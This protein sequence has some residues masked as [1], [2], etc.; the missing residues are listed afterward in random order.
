MILNSIVRDHFNAVQRYWIDFLFVMRKMLQLMICSLYSISARFSCSYTNSG[1]LFL[2]LIDPSAYLNYMF[3]HWKSIFVYRNKSMQSRVE[4]N[5]WRK[6]WNKMNLFSLTN[7]YHNT[8]ITQSKQSRWF[9]WSLFCICVF[10]FV[11]FWWTNTHWA[12][13]MKE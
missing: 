5:L 10:L 11:R 3:R 9:C 4:H 12:Q 8:I 1:W 13:W 6:R 7:L 2:T